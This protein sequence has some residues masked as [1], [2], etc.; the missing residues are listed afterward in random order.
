VFFGPILEDFSGPSRVFLSSFYL[1]LSVANNFLSPPLY[2]YLYC[3]E[4]KKI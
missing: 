3:I 2:I 1:N 4:L